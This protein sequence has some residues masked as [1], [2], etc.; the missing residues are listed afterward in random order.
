MG[1]PCTINK[2][3]RSELKDKLKANRYSYIK[4]IG[5]YKKVKEHPLLI[6]NITRKELLDLGYDYNQESVIFA[7]RIDNKMSFEYW[8]KKESKHKKID[9]SG[10]GQIYKKIEVYTGN[11]EYLLDNETDFTRIGNWKFKIPFDYFK[12]FEQSFSI[13]DF[14]KIVEMSN[15]I[16]DENISGKHRWHLRVRINRILREQKK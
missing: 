5:N 11:L 6:L 9:G 15:E 16:A 14:K 1:E 8:E 2:K 7:E 4:I 12:Q 3:L 10:E 13:K